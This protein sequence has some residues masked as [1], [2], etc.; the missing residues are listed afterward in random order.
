MSDRSRRSLVLLLKIGAGL[1]V[2][3]WLLGTIDLRSAAAA[4]AA[5][6]SG[7]T[8]LG[9]G[10]LAAAPAMQILRFRVLAGKLG[11]TLGASARITLA[12]TLFNQLL[13]GGLGGEGYRALRLRR[14]TERWPAAIGLVATERIVGALSLLIPGFL[15]AALESSRLRALLAQHGTRLSFLGS[16]G[17][18][19]LLG[20]LAL[21]AVALWWLLRR[22]RPVRVAAAR[23]AAEVQASLTAIGA[24]RYLGVLALS[25]A[26]HA[27][28]LAG[29]GSLLA[30]LGQG[31]AVADLVF[32]LSLTL[33]VS[34]LPLTLGALGF[35]EG[36]IV[37]GLSLFGV[38]K[39][40]ALAV[41]LLNRIVLLLLA[42][43]GGVVLLFE[44][45]S[46]PF[47]TG[48]L[49]R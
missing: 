4:L 2:L 30:G 14:L 38:A 47:G 22:S 41:A 34:T 23:W 18:T 37:L 42:L 15:Y 19:S 31:I 24:P 40:H 8:W 13:P 11:L 9:V 32:A 33:A 45:E 17:A 43:G 36:T 5:G 49:P 6:D 48:R 16:P 46:E 27:V 1:A 44:K 25:V 7:K 10:L 21:S 39:S 12:A 26:Y 28:R 35:K 20:A 3:A 29:F